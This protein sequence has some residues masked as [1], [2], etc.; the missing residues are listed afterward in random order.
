MLYLLLGPDDFSKKEHI[1][2]LAQKEALRLEFFVDPASPPDLRQLA[3]QDLFNKPKIFVLANL[4]GNIDITANAENL[5]KAANHIFLI[6][7]KLDKRS[8]ENKKLLANKSITVK[9]FTLPHGQDLDKWIVSRAKELGGQ[10][11]KEAAGELARRLGRDEAKET[12]VAGKVVAVE[13]IYNLS[14]ADNEIKKLLAFANGREIGM[15]DVVNL[16]FENFETDVFEITNA[17]ADGKKTEALT[18]IKNFLSFE[19]GS[20]EKSGIIQ[21]NALLSEQFRNVAMVQS[22]AADRVNESSILEKTGWKS[23]RLFIMKKIA[24]K[25]APSKVLDFLNKLEALDEELKTSQTPPKV[26]LDLILVQLF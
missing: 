26:L 17:I 6:E 10:I 12:K 3:S 25:F 18:L 11:S 24:G 2:S 22:F 9:E 1:Y 20:E 23:G 8:T 5:A 21:L 4:L 14:Q 19:T 7:Q 13:E 15:D 16:V